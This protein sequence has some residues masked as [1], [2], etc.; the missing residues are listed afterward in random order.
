MI[1]FGREVCG[2]LAE[3]LTREW[4]ETN[5]IGGFASSTIAG[6]NTRRYHGLLVAAVQPPVGRTVLLSKLE[7]TLIVG[8]QRFELSANRY[9]GVVHPRGHR[10]LV[11]FRLDPFPVFTYELEGFEFEKTVFMIHGENTT[12]VQYDLKNDGPFQL[13]LRPLVA[14]R[15]YH[16]LTHENQAI[17]PHVE[18]DTTSIRIQ[19][20]PGM[21]AL[22]LTH[23]NGDVSASGYWHRHFEYDAERARGLDFVEDLFNPCV[24]T[25]ELHAGRP[26]VIVAS[27][28]RVERERAEEASRSEQ[29]RRRSIVAASPN[30]DDLTR[31]LVTA[32]D[33]FIVARREG[34]TVIAG[35][36]WFTD[37]GR[38]TMVSIPG[39]ALV[40][41]RVE[42][43]RRILVE[44]A[45]HVDRGMIPNRFPDAGEQPEY[46][47]VDATLWFVYAVQMLLAQRHDDAFVRECLYDVLTDIMAWHVRGTRHGIRVDEDGLLAAGP[48]EH[49]LTWMDVKI[50]D[51]IVTPRFGKPVEVQALWY[52]ALRVMERLAKRHG[53][54]PRRMQYANLADRARRS[55]NRLFWNQ[56]TGCLDDVVHE[57]S[58]DPAIRPNQ[59]LALSLP[60]S[61]VSRERAVSILGVVERLLLTRYGLRTL[62][63]T[64]PRYCGRYDGGPRRRDA[65]YHQGTVWPW[66]IGPFATAYLGFAREENAPAKVA[67]WLAPFRDHLADAGLGQVSEVF[68]GDPPHRPGGCIAQ[69]WSVAE[70]LRIAAKALASATESTRVGGQT[71][72]VDADSRRGQRSCAV[73][74]RL[75]DVVTPTND[76]AM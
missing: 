34:K 50:G 1:R 46:T 22:Y 11:Q 32:A 61:M 23:D 72:I 7:E 47:S 67:A 65:A 35:Y 12:V 10:F 42:V 73:S 37:W 44:F 25:L 9:P 17:D 60:F 59:I 71:S 41:G 5:G 21:P 31:T 70:L 64:D 75:D 66:L 29:E 4:L 69:A 8:A 24:L 15:D 39:L 18:T 45:R 14:F 6:L 49:P 54:E 63:P 19:P 40:T 52:N 13:E 57:T 28:R 58:R 36:H 68:D 53:D 3:A 56:T 38:D 16:G 51:W 30:P 48:A 43:A 74:S 2:N 62:A 76:S 27:T 55:F 20:Y 33:Q 26:L